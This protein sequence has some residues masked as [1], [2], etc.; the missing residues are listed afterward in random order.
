MFGG[1]GFG[2]GRQGQKKGP[3]LETKIRVTLEELFVGKEIKV[4]RFL[5]IKKVHDIKRSIM[6]AL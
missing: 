6:W 5:L 1:G 2:G 4:S 3:P